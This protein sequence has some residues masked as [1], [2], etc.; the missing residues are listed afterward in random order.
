MVQ[1][2]KSIQ[3]VE[4]QHSASVLSQIV[5]IFIDNGSSISRRRK[6]IEPVRTGSSEE[7]NRF[8]EKIRI[9]NGLRWILNTKKNNYSSSGK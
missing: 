5:E 3:G 7:T 9:F 6:T 8:L 2:Q 1:K 4:K